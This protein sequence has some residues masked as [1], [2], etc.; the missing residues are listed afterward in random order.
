MALGS[1]PV[2]GYLFG[3]RIGQVP[4]GPQAVLDQTLAGVRQVEAQGLHAS[5]DTRTHTV[6][7]IAPRV[8][9]LLRH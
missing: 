5:Y 8:N 2:L 6:N 3:G 1:S 9:L 7:A 4:E